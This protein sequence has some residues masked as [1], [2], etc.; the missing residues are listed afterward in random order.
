MNVMTAGII[1]RSFVQDIFFPLHGVRALGGWAWSLFNVR[2]S[3]ASISWTITLSHPLDPLS[4]VHLHSPLSMLCFS[5]SSDF[6][7]VSGQRSSPYTNSGLSPV[8]KAC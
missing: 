4:V 2:Y 5:L 6:K 3:L 8:F 1:G 7:R